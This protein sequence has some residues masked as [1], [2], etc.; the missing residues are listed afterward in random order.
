MISIR[1]STAFVAAASILL[2]AC[3]TPG[4]SGGRSSAIGPQL[5]SLLGQEAEAPS[6]PNRPKID[7]VIPVFDPGIEPEDVDEYEQLR[8]NNYRDGGSDDVV[9]AADYVWPELRRAEA[10]RFAYKLKLKE[11][12]EDTGEFGA[13]RVTPDA[14]AT[15]DLYLLGRITESDGEDV[16]FELAAVDISGDQWFKQSFDH[17]VEDDF[18]KNIPNDGKD[19]YDPAFGEAAEYLVDELEYYQTD[20]LDTIRKVADLRFAS[21]FTEDAFENH[22]TVESSGKFQLA[23][24]PSS[25]DPMLQRTKSIR[26][27]DQLFVDGL[28]RNYEDFSDQMDTSYLIWQEQ[29]MLELQAKREAQ[30]EAIGEGIL[31]VL[32][33]GL[34]VAAIAAGAQ[35]DDY[36]SSV[37]STSAGIAAGTVGAMLLS[38]SFQT[39]KEAEIHREALDE[40]GESID[41]ELA[42]QVVKFEQETL[43]LQGTASEQFAQWREFLQRIYAEES[44][45]DVQL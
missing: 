16:E 38:E 15:G 40:L 9:T 30:L 17:T 32:A 36:N 20:E 26:V 31:G 19:P 27:R 44:T 11:A 7:I 29:S 22:L 23:S 13:V 25:E 14:T 33:I 10:I 35:S 3:V 1:K 43:E 37:A 45:P 28:Q 18:H 12:I 21:H 4:G 2:S 24:Y 39:S 5:S 42:P 8:H 41:L 6:D 34:A